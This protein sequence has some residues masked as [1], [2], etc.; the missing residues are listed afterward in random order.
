MEWNEKRLPEEYIKLGFAIEEYLPGYVDSY[1][2]PD[3][4]ATQAKQ[5]GKLPLQNLTERTAQLARIISQA[6]GMDAQ[7]K[8]FFIRQVTAMQMSLRLFSG[9]KISLAE[10]VKA[11]YDVQPD[12]VN[13]SQF[14]EAHKELE[15][16]LPPGD[17]LAERLQDWNRSLEIPIEKAKELFPL[18][19]KRLRE[20]THQRFNL[21]D[22]EDFTLEFVSDKPWGAYNLYLGSFRS[23]I[24]INIDLPIRVTGL[25]NLI[26]HEGYPGHHTELALKEQNLVRQK[27]YQE[28][29]IALLNSPSCVVAE[30]IAT[31]ALETILTDSEME[32]WYRQDLLS[33][34]GKSHI[35][36]KTI[37][38]IS[39]AF[40]K[41]KGIMGNLSFMLYDQ[42]KSVEEAESYLQRYALATEKERKHLIRFISDPLSR[43]YVFTY[44]MGYDLLEELFAH[45]DRDI[46][47]K[48]LL[49]EP[50]TP[51][52]IREWISTNS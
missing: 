6:D 41:T 10:E 9:E 11:L 42:H 35:D 38:E 52:Q 51:S 7:R 22:E 8:D 32:V 1:F 48:R 47:F 21:P 4:W 5:D 39:N 30:G 50:V 16:L 49:E 19:A 15:A 20:L 18:V 37:M 17:S 31:C 34:A 40:R 43:S 13:E 24:D 12:W 46:Y 36:P 25:A 2:G 3:E 28:H 33:H 27:N 44:D 29:T 45:V 26:A 23:R 14:E